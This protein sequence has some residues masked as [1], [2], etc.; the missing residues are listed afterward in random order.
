MFGTTSQ[1]VSYTTVSESDKRKNGFGSRKTGCKSSHTLYRPESCGFS[2]FHFRIS[3]SDRPPPDNGGPV[4]DNL[5]IGFWTKLSRTINSLQRQ[6]S[7]T[8][9][10]EFA[11]SEH[12]SAYRSSCVGGARE[13]TPRALHARRVVFPLAPV[14]LVHQQ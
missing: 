1:A 11:A 8:Y 6:S 9:L 3:S 2:V 5:Q 7:T 4:S 10:Y 14:D 12:L 13:N